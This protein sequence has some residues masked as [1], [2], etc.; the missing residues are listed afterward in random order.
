MLFDPEFTGQLPPPPASASSI[1]AVGAI[2]SIMFLLGVA[3][4]VMRLRTHGLRLTFMHR[5]GRRSYAPRATITTLPVHD[6]AERA[7]RQ[8]A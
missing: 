2:V 7:R 6:A 8:S 3:L 1:H 5:R 4:L